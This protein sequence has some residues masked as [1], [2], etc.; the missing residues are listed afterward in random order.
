MRRSHWFT[1]LKRWFLLSDDRGQQI[2]RISSAVVISIGCLVL[3][4]WALKIPLLKTLGA[5]GNM[6]ANVAVGLILAGVS[7]GLI[8]RKRFNRQT[9]YIARACTTILGAIG[10]LTLIQYATGWNFGIDELLFRDPFPYPPLYPGRMGLPAA[11]N[12]SLIS[13]ALWLS[14]EVEDSQNRDSQVQFPRTWIAQS[15]A[16]IVSVISLQALVVRAYGLPFASLFGSAVTAMGGHTAFAFM[17]LGIGVLALKSVDPKEGTATQRGWM[18]IITSDSIGGMVARRFLPVAIGLPL[19]LGWL[20]MQGRRANWYPP[21]YGT[22][23]MSIAFVVVSVVLIVS[24][25]DRLNRVDYDRKRSSD[26]LRSS[27]ERLKLAQIA[28]NTGSW[29]WNVQTG[30]LFWSE[31][32]YSLMG[33]SQTETDLMAVFLSRVDP[34]DLPHIEAIVQQITSIESLDLEYRYLHPDR[35]TRW[36]FSKYAIAPDNPAIVRGVVID[37]TNRK[38]AELD[39][40]QDQETIQQQFAE[41]EAIYHTAPIGLAVLD[42]DLRFVRLNHRL[43]EI[44]GLSVDA[45]LGRTVREI[46]P[47]LADEVE[48]LFRRVL[49]TGEPLLNLELAGETVAQPGVQRTWIENWYPLQDATGRTIAI[50]AVVQEITQRK[51]TEIT[52][53]ESESRFR[54]LADNISQLAWIADASGWINWYNQRW[55]DYTGTT[56][57]QM[58]GWGWQTVHHPDHVDRVVAH[59]R[60]CFEIGE[61]WEDTFPLRGRNGQ[62][63][64]FLSRAIPIRDDQ[65]TILRWFGTNTD[66]TDRKTLEETLATQAEELRQANRLKDEFLAALSHELRTPL[67]PILGWTKMMRSQRLTPAKTTEALEIIERNVKQQISLV[68]DL[69]DVSRVIQGKL[70]LKLQPV[71]LTTIVKS[72]IDTIQFAAQ[73]KRIE[74]EVNNGTI[75]PVMGDRDRLQQVFWNLLNNAIKFTPEG[76]HIQIDQFMDTN[77]NGTQSAQI[78]ITDNGIGISPEFLPHVFDHFRQADGSETREYGGLGL[79]LSIVRHLVE[80]HG[81]TITAESFGAGQGASFTVSLPSRNLVAVSSHPITPTSSEIDST[82]LPELEPSDSVSSA[83]MTGSTGALAGLQI[84]IVDDDRDNL[85]LLRFLLQAD[86]AIVTALTSPQAALDRIAQTPSDLIISDVGMPQMSGYE[87]IRRVRALPQGSRIPALAL[88]AF[89]RTEDQ[90]EALQAGFQRYVTKPVDPIE[91][92]S[93]LLQLLQP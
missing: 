66:I 17:V 88:T 91:L 2:A 29:E 78:R 38:Q 53:R 25:A 44:N 40:V 54:T 6:R 18:R 12:L 56:I 52:L 63:R 19:I 70:K 82:P 59:F 32:C 47:N 55:F 49:E 71:D 42:R 3:L 33:I 10:V 73:A 76:G 79:G 11:I 4:G 9:V 74:L 37:I 87:L 92:L 60:H 22:S 90:A 14:S 80:L 85:D 28:T 15:L 65:G 8:A 45:H 39:R 69:L 7:L 83:P 89:A 26:R 58:Q 51:R 86:G 77:R 34:E 50:N 61:T 31:S 24:S 64:W 67:N 35:G 62:Y 1:R 81:G 68:D 43:A 57:E 27:E 5:G 21:G 16:A 36:L 72:A 30:E 41:I 23:L 46:V 13:I 93:T 48:P 84:L 75:L 20:I